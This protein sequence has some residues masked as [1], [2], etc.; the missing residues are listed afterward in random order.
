MSSGQDVSKAETTMSA[1]ISRLENQNT[2]LRGVEMRLARLIGRL[3]GTDSP[4]TGETGQTEKPT[5]GLLAQLDEQLSENNR[6]SNRLAEL[7][8]R[9]EE[10]A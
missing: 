4:P 10:L 1:T 3:D 7:T 9:L 2:N 6:W 8:Q 5:P